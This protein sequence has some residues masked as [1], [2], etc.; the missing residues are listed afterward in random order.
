E[1]DNGSSSDSSDESPSTDD[2]DGNSNGSESNGSGDNNDSDNNDNN[3]GTGGSGNEVT[4]EPEPEPNPDPEPEL[5]YDEL[6]GAI[7]NGNSLL[8]EKHRYKGIS[9]NHFVS[10][11]N[12]ANKVLNNAT[13]QSS[14]DSATNRLVS[15]INGLEVKDPTI[16]V[17]GLEELE[18]KNNDIT[19]DRIFKLNVISTDVDGKKLRSSIKVNGFPVLSFTDTYNLVLLN[20]DNKVTITT[21]DSYGNNVEKSFTINHVTDLTPEI[22]HS[23]ISNESVKDGKFI[24]D[25]EAFDYKDDILDVTATHNGEEVEIKNGKLVVDLVE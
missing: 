10:S 18:G 19:L 20:G 13:S 24:L 23:S 15:S 17:T 6:W 1:S 2:G 14:I 22:E 3:G 9:W 7:S 5:S 21:K 16:T 4:P 25:V 8:Y 12:N 11:L